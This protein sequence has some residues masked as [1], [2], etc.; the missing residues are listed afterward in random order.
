MIMNESAL[1]PIYG[2]VISPIHLII[3]VAITCLWGFNFSVIKAGV[4]NIDP[5]VLTGLRFTFAAFPAILFVRKPDVSWFYI[6]LY[7]IIFGVGVWGMMSMSIYTGLS[8]GIASIILELSAFISVLM[9]VIFLKER[10]STSLKIGLALSLLGLVVI[11]NITDGSVTLVGFIFAFIGAIG[12]SS[13]SL[14][15]KKLAIKDMFAFVAWSCLFAP[16]PLFAMA[17]LVNGVN[18]Y[19]ELT[20]SLNST[21][22]AS[23]LFQAYPTTLLGYWVWNKMLIKY[24]LSVMSPFKLLVPIF[25]LL[26]SVIFYDEQLEINKIIAFSLIMAGVVAPLI[27]PLFTQRIM[28]FLTR[29]LTPFIKS[30]KQ[31]VKPE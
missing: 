16:L 7:G 8:A 2:K 24:P 1:S 29:L 14:M 19:E 28:P 3:I 23:V 17:Y 21:A 22:F 15:V 4:D 31:K 13:I 10:I 20:T 26:G 9:G 6:A 27:V 12:F 25:A 18:L 30:I 5:Y 11:A